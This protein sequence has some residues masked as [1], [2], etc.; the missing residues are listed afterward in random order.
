MGPARDH[1]SLP[2]ESVHSGSATIQDKGVSIV[3]KG[4][5][6]SVTSMGHGVYRQIKFISNKAI[7]TGQHD[8]GGVEG[9]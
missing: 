4:G 5:A 8:P 1:S 6:V 7:V 9:G 3:G 2:F